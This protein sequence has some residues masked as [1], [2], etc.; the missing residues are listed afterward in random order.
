MDADC[1]QY[2]RR[3][4]AVSQKWR[5]DRLL[6]K[7]AQEGV[8]I[9]VIVYRNIGAAIPIDSV[10][11]KYSLLDLHPNIFVQRSPNQIR[12]NTFFW[13]HHEKI[14]VVDHMIAF[15]GG[16][17]LCF[18]RWD[19]QV[20][21]RKEVPIQIRTTSSSGLERITLIRECKISSIWINPTKICTIAR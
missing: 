21:S 2:L 7:K 6:Q 5:L 12:Q 3:P 4:A 11:T 19:T 16:I 18:G 13:A 15:V 9:F 1:V 10:Y 20:G 17:D 8:K 14:L